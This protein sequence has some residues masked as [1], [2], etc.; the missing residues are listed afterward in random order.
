M[1]LPVYFEAEPVV[2]DV[3]RRV[4]QVLGNHDLWEHGV[5]T[6]QDYFEVI[7]EYSTFAIG[8]RWWFRGEG[9][10]FEFPC[11]PRFARDYYSLEGAEPLRDRNELELLTPPESDKFGTDVALSCITRQEVNI[12]EAFKQEAP[13]DRYFDGS[14]GKG[15]NG[16]VWLSFAQ[17]HGLRT[18][19]LDVT[20]DPLVALFFACKDSPHDDGFVWLYPQ[21]LPI[22][23][24]C[25]DRHTD[26]RTAFDAG[27]VDLEGLRAFREGTLSQF[28]ATRPPNPRPD[29]HLL[30]LDEEPTHRMISQRGQFLWCPR[31]LQPLN[32]GCSAVRI[33]SSAKEDLLWL[34]SA[35]GIHEATLQLA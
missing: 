1:A 17:H 2:A 7:S 11:L 28:A 32:I 10:E 35:F 19:L 12:I 29:N 13:Q 21:T 15:K 16:P 4:L 5:R 18:R 14:V 24:D 27:T 22:S 25:G 33:A 23:A 26:Y 6:L 34:L 31:P 3:N 8:E 30:D 9:R 20:S